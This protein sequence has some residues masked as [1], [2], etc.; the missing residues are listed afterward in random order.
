MVSRLFR[1]QEGAGSTPA[2]PTA[3]ARSSEAE[4]RVYTPGKRGFKSLRADPSTRSSGVEHSADNRATRVRFPTG[5]RS[6]PGFSGEDDGALNA[7]RWGSSPFPG[8]VA[9]GEESS[10]DTVNVTQAGSSPAGH[11]A[12]GRGVVV[13]RLLWE[14]VNAGSNPV[15]QTKAA[16]K[17]GT[18]VGLETVDTKGGPPGRR[19]A[20]QA[21]RGGF[22]S[23]ALHQS[24]D[25]GSNP[26]GP[27][28]T[29]PS[30][31]RGQRTL[32]CDLGSG[33][34][35]NA[36]SG[37]R[38]LDGPRARWCW[39]K[40]SPR[41]NRAVPQCKDGRA[42]WGAPPMVANGVRTPGVSRKRTEFDSSAL[43]HGAFGFR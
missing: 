15:A 16:I 26:A 25:A 34:A 35:P 8:T 5:G 36:A 40:S 39:F 1:E 14:Q 24:E 43:L 41:D 2:I 19:D 27:T 4:L 20:L 3:S 37:V 42:T 38:F 12:P 11:P 33:G 7:D 23:L 29:G 21:T 22:N 9:E 13:A 6:D 17:R 10:R 31:K 32:G 30:S 28:N 18:R